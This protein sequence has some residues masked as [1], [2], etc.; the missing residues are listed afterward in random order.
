[1]LTTRVDLLNG[2]RATAL[3]ELP[4]LSRDRELSKLEAAVRSCTPTLIEGSPGL[5]K[6]RLLLE[7]SR[8]FSHG[9]AAS[10]YVRFSQPLHSFLV[11]LAKALSL[12]SGRASSVTLRGAIWKEFESRPRVLLLDD[13]GN[14]GPLFHRF[15]ERIQAIQGSVLI[16]SACEAHGIGVLQRAF[17]NPQTTLRLHPLNKQDADHLI[18]AA[19]QTFLHD[20][21]IPSDFAHRIA[22]AARG[23]PGRIVDMCLRATNKAYWDRE[24]RIRFGALLMDSVAGSLP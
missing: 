7:L 22:Q 10:V 14:A 9:N 15:F 3:R 21:P 8:R 2:N 16:G 13:I 17:W 5:G 4:L 1:M 11:D 18:S 20:C 23:N 6:T 24:E 12:E 19:V